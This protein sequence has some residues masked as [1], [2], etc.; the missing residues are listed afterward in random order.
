MAKMVGRENRDAEAVV[1]DMSSRAA[2]PASAADADGISRQIRARRSV[3]TEQFSGEEVHREEVELLLE[4]AHWAPNH[5]KTEPWFFQV[6]SGEGRRRLG[7]AHAAL[8]RQHT[9]PALFREETFDKL[10]QRPIDCS[11][12]I[13]I[14]MKRG[15]NPKIPVIEEVEAVACAVQNLWLTASALGLAGYWSSGGMTYHPAFRDWLGLGPEDQCL[16]LFMLGRP[17]AAPPEGKRRA[18]WQDKVRWVES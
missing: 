12:V 1:A 9:D 3:F 2:A 15:E 13:V 16:G 18:P 8:Y 7:E 5:G 11:H 17:K 10:R 14:C 4:N 6:F